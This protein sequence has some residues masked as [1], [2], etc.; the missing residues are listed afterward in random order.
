MITNQVNFKKYHKKLH[1]ALF[2]NV[3]ICTE[4]FTE[5][6][7]RVLLRKFSKVYIRENGT[8]RFLSPVQYLVEAIK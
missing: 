5:H 2:K 3:N 6:G 7:L 4:V 1:M 8:D